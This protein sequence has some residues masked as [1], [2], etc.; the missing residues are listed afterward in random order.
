MNQGYVNSWEKKYLEQLV[1]FLTEYYAT[2]HQPPGLPIAV[3]VKFDNFRGP[4]I[5]NIP[6]CVPVCS[7]TITCNTF[8]GVHERHQLP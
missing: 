7:M 3:I 6:G 4:S 8:D 5:N 1:L 2:N